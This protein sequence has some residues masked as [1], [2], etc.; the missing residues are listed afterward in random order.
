[1]QKENL[2]NKKVFLIINSYYIGDI[3]LAN[4]LVQNIKAIYK[5]SYVVMLTPP[6]MV[7]AAKYQDGVD[8]VIIW[9]RH[10]TH[11]GW[12]NMFKFILN[13]PYKNIYAAFPIYSGDR[14]II[15]AFLLKAKYILGKRRN[16]IGI[17]LKNKYKINYYIFDGV[18]G[19]NISILSG[20]TKEKLKNYPIK[21]NIP[22]V[23]SEI[24]K[25]DENYIVI[26][27]TSSKAEKDMP[28]KD[29]CKIIESLKYKVVLLGKGE[30]SK[31]LSEFLQNKNYTNL[32]DLSNK[33]SFLE[34]AKIISLSKGCISVDTGSL[35]LACAL[36]KPTIGVFY[37]NQNVL[38]KPD[39]KIY[40]NMFCDYDLT[41]EKITEKLNI[42]INR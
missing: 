39:S 37:K 20:I 10:G 32:I 30:T 33:T 9:D 22:D 29:V 19:R 27:P 14:A 40:P 28:I 38:Y 31:Q 41:A 16:I 26:C 35:H 21:I 23:Q 5:D 25:I 24:C 2:K 7:D 4:S 13:F 34:L 15:L 6:N 42:L 11:H 17:F 8:D 18:Q 36:N 12:F 3:L 1:M